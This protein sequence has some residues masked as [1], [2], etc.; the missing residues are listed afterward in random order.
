[1][2]RKT[3]KKTT[4][5]KTRKAPNKWNKFV[6]SVFGEMK[7][8]NKNVSFSDALKEASKRKKKGQY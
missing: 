6:M 2:R 4:A 8:A 7:K 1:M 3:H 5:R